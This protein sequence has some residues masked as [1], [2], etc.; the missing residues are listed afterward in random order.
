M[1]KNFPPF[2]LHVMRALAVVED[3]HA[4]MLENS[5]AALYKGMWVSNKSIHEPAV[6]GAILSE[7]LGEERAKEV[8]EDR[9]LLMEKSQSTKPEAKAKLQ[10]NTDMAFEEGAFGLPWFV[11][12]NAQGEVDR[13]WGFDHMGL[14]V[15]H[16]GLD[17]GDLKE[18][19]AML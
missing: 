6:F 9:Q 12:T 10:K 2:T 7:V 11:A 5:I 17:G 3:K 19:R 14:M 18:L 4:S 13:F 8:V 16:L 1:P 15:E